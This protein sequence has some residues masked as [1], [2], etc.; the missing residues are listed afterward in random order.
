MLL[1][2]PR[3]PL[4]IGA[5]AL[6][7]V[8]LGLLASDRLAAGL[9]R[10]FK[11]QLEQTLSRQLGQPLGLGD[12]VGLRPWGLLVGPSQLKPTASGRSKVTAQSLQ[13]ALAP[14]ATIKNG[15]PSL[16]LAVGGAAAE[17]IANEQ[18]RYWSLPP[19]R[20][21]AKPPAL[22]LRVVLRQSA[23][24][25]L[26]QQSG[27]FALSGALDLQLQR[28]RLALDAVLRPQTGGG[29][30][31]VSGHGG[32]RPSQWRLGL[33]LDRLRL[34]DMAALLPINSRLRAPGQASGQVML[35]LAPQRSSCQGN[36]QL[37]GLLWPGPQASGGRGIERLVLSCQ[38]QRLTLQPTTVR[39]G[40]WQA[41][42]R[43]QARWI[44]G[45]GLSLETLEL[46]RG[47]SSMQLKGPVQRTLALSSQLAIWPGDLP[48]G[49]RLPGWLQQ[50][51]FTGELTLR[52]SWR[53]PQ[54]KL[55]LSNRRDPLLGP[56][57][58]EL[59]WKPTQTPLRL[60]SL[61]SEHLQ[62]SGALPLQLKPGRGLQSGPLQ[63]ELNLSR[64][65]LARLQPLVG[66][67]LAGSLD[68]QGRISGPL[69]ALVPELELSVDQLGAGPLV[70]NEL[71]QGRWQG[72]AAGGGELSM[73]SLAPAPEAR[74][75]ASFNPRWL[76]TSIS[77][78]RGDGE[79][80]L[81]GKPSAYRWQARALLLD[82]LALR[83][84]PRALPQGLRGRLS[85][86]GQVG[87]Q[88]FGFSGSAE[89][90]R[91]SVLGLRLM[92][93]SLQGRY[94]RERYQLQGQLKPTA[95]SQ[96][97]LEARGG[98]RG[99]LALHVSARALERDTLQQVVDLWP[100]WQGRE[101]R[102]AGRASDL[103]TLMITTLGQS[104]QQQLGALADARA[105]L[106]AS[107]RTGGDGASLQQRLR[108][109]R[110]RVDAD[111]GVRGPTARQLKLDLAAKGHLWLA[112]QEQ[113]LVLST[114]PVTLRLDGPLTLGQ[115]SFDLSN[116]PLS[117]LALL[118]P[119]PDSLRGALTLQGRYGLGRGRRE[120]N[121]ALGL[122]G[123]ELAGRSLRLSR[124]EVVLAGDALKLDLALQAEG[125][126][127]SIDLAGV[128]PLDPD[129]QGLELRLASRDDGLRML[130][131]LAEPDLLWRK[132][133]AD[134]QLLL[135]G[136]VSKPIANG[137]LRIRDG[138]L[139][140]LKQTVEALEATIVFDFEQ[141]LVQELRAQVGP[142]G[143]ITASGH[144]GL[145]TPTSTQP[146]L[147]VQLNQVPFSVPRITAIAD[148]Q[149]E[150]GGSLSDLQMAG[151]VAVDRG[152]I[153]AQ[154]GRLVAA[155]PSSKPQAPRQSVSQ[156]LQENWDFQSPLLLIGAE[157]QTNSSRNVL[158]AVPRFKPL[159]F[160][161][162]RVK[163]GPNLRIVI[164]NAASFKSAGL[165]RLTGR[166][167]PTLRARGVVRLLQG[168]LNLF[169]TSFSLDPDAPNVAVFTPALGLVPY[170]DIAMRTRV[171][172][173][174]AISGLGSAG[175]P[176]LAEIEAQG[177][178]SNLNQLNL[179]RITVT[180]SGPADRLAQSIRLRSSPPLPE[181]KLIAL[182]GGN[183]LAG[184]GGAGA[185]AAIATVV[186]QTLLSP[187]LGGLSD[188]FGQRVSF[189]LYPTYL[190]PNVTNQAVLQS[191]RLA[192]QLVLGSEIGL[193]ITE[194]FNVSVLAAPNRSDVPPQLNL[195]V[196]ATD[197]LNVQGS[198]DSQGALQGQLQLFFRF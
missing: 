113:D 17:L 26:P 80:S 193:D 29:S 167:D 141:L 43:G 191:Q 145:V 101:Q 24:L 68:A 187:V 117:L 157:A 25:T 172:D 98:R 77:L 152:S 130:T 153:N 182:I 181:S 23:A 88:P 57:R 105:Q 162:L 156:L 126:S 22:A 59:S 39:W 144:L 19:S 44:N 135:R 116:L 137:F 120:L 175:S 185:G 7:S 155:R 51:Q 104:L 16:E 41:Q 194:R 90:Q 83:L 183:S 82:G 158:Q 148:G 63:L 174:V 84:G 159:G 140:L 168:R 64:Y 38:Q 198:V 81:R 96:L 76:P 92:S 125:T 186:G 47:R 35:Q 69:A 94:G 121:L 50:Q 160:N 56:W 62:A 42:A 54:L 27:R 179:V 67:Q 161:D 20:P 4:L 109:L 1:P 102:A 74:L 111:L 13:L 2:W 115:G 178:L 118:T 177:G 21:R 52:G 66:A 154:P 128:L 58:A 165:L 91:P 3:R 151:E 133:S 93:A 166:L 112:E 36:L 132:G 86:T 138:Q 176:S 150:I 32:W 5:G 97:S 129:R 134:L 131:A 78:K 114:E 28:R 190:N 61:R 49:Q 40:T 87:L 85:G 46:R 45:K 72:S 100:Q 34:S 196:R 197:I 164:P 169:T 142:A 70:L 122:T 14:I 110:L 8:A 55:N 30:L 15:L 60:V 107:G 53:Q 31:R 6:G 11:P 33:A 146:P 10:Q 18:G 79:L 108:Q 12:Y 139:S 119:V 195:N 48:Q 143:S 149:L 192:P 103:G 89:L 136:S 173:S 9:Y 163:L 189:A 106:I 171:A 123:A 147:T 124:G 73:L 184:L 127:S 71:W 180:V 65:P 75:K 188:A 99:A 37:Q 95:Q 170:L